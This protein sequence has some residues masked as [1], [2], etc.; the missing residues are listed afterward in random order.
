[1]LASDEVDGSVLQQGREHEEQTDSHPDV[2]GFDVGHLQREKGEC[3]GFSASQWAM[4]VWSKAEASPPT[5]SHHR[6]GGRMGR[7][8]TPP[9]RL[10]RLAPHDVMMLLSE[11]L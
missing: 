3:T 7:N 5:V 10:H 8:S 1:M 4:T 9:S 6:A 2:N 11:I